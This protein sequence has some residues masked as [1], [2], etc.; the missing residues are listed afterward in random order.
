MSATPVKELDLPVVEDRGIGAFDLDAVR[1]VWDD[2]HWLARSRLGYVVLRYDDV[3]AILRDRR[4]YSASSRRPEL[5]TPGAKR[6][7][8]I[9]EMDGDEHTRLRRL[10]SPAFTPKAAD[11]L[12]PYM[13]ET[14]A[15][16]LDA[17]LSKGRCEAFTEL[18]VPYPVPVICELLGAPKEDLPQFTTWADQ[19][20]RKFDLDPKPYMDQ[21]R[22]ATKE[23]E[24]YA[25]ALIERR[26]ETPSDDLLS[27]LIAV[28]KQGDR[29]SEDELTSMV[30]T[31]LLAGTDTTRNQL[32]CC[33]AVLVDHPDQWS[34]LC[35]R[36][37]LAANAVEETMRFVATLRGA[38]R[39]A[40]EDVVYRDILF[41][42]GT[43]IW[44]S[45]VT[46]NRDPAQWADADRLDITA[47]R[48]SQQMSFGSGVHYCL[49]VNLA[50]AELQEALTMLAERA[51]GMAADGDVVWR[52]ETVG[53]WGPSEVPVRF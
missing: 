23:L 11:R 41:P 44:T 39:F 48:T 29:L 40:S 17:A 21:I 51:P 30:Q 50:R 36:P 42:K 25:L 8:L 37:E 33:I 31:I 19:I 9:I 24:E 32:A 49:G 1:A 26:R 10:V 4:F 28:E 47:V 2:G 6:R 43:L 22:T 7:P 35:E 27:E 3:F 16:L 12:R 18:C 52:P 53:I 34:L 13:R 38:M 45:A 15:E 20:N 14:F 5:N 46:A